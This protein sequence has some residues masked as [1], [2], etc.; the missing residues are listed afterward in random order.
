MTSIYSTFPSQK[1]ED[2]CGYCHEPIKNTD[3]VA[4]GGE[5]GKK[6]PLH[7]ECAK[8]VACGSNLCP[9]CKT[10]IDRASL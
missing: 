1:Y 5:H 9:T 7:R 3:A 4:H 10:L 8:T 6:H 2:N